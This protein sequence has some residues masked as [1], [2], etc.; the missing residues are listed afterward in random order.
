MDTINAVNIICLSVI[1]TRL[2]N[3]FFGGGVLIEGGFAGAEEVSLLKSK[4][5]NVK[6]FAI[7]PAVKIQNDAETSMPNWS[8]AI[9][10]PIVSIIANPND[11]TKKE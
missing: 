11:I 8:P 2:K 6:T 3:R 4:S 7:P 9:C 10:A 1:F 5:A